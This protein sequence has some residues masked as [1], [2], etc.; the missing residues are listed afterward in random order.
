MNT[1]ARLI[2]LSLVS[3]T[4]LAACG[5]GGGGGATSPPPPPPPPPPPTQSAGGIWGGLAVTQGP[6][7]VATSFEFN[8]V[9]PFSI[10]ASPF[11]ATFSNGNAE[12][13]GQGDLYSTGAFAW[14]ILTGTA[15]TVTFETDPSTLSFS[16]RTEFAADVSDIQ[17]LDEN[18]A[19][20]RSVTPTNVF[21]LIAVNRAAGETPI[22]SMVVTSTSGGDVVIDDLTFGYLDTTD[23]IACVVA[24]TME[25]VCVVTDTTTDTLVA[26][27]QGTVQVTGSQVTGSGTLHAA[28]GTTL[29]DGS[30]TSNLTINAGTVSEGNSLDLTAGA[31]GTSTSIATI[32]DATYDRGS[33]LATV[34][35]AYSTFDIFGDPA[36]FSV[37]AGGAITSQSNSG[38][39]ANGQISIID[40]NFN[41]YDV[42]LDVSSCGGLNGMYDGLGVTQDENATDDVF[43]FGVFTSQSMIAGEAVK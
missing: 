38:C 2:S 27:A 22:G 4:L 10:G 14:H 23:N 16:V 39:V 42:T 32:F 29:A 25:F 36:S 31:A 6:A 11:T 13:R 28:P 9:G 15:A 40:A 35:A 43:V 3:L 8:A 12:S 7:D 37:D 19:L 18:G 26:A 24:D 5:G 1:L 17:I 30:T 41:A 20:I 34:A 21:Q 33:D